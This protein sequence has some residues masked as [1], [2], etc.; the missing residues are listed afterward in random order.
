MPDTNVNLM[1]LGNRALLDSTP[2]SNITQTQAN[3]IRNWTAQGSDQ[4]EAV[5]LRGNYYETSDVNGPH[6][7]TT[8]LATSSAP[9]SQ[10][11]YTSPSTG[12]VVSGIRIQTFL[13][14]NYSIT[15]HDGAGNATVVK[16]TGVLIQ[17]SN[18]DLFFRPSTSTLN[19]W[20]NIDRISEVTIDSVSV[21]TSHVATMGFKASIFD[22][23][24]VCFTR[25]T[26][27]DTPD[28][29]RPVEDLRIGDLVLTLDRGA[30]PIRWIGSRKLDIELACIPRLRPVR[31]RA[32][33]LGAGVPKADL[34]VSP[35]HRVLLRSRIAARMFGAAEVLV[36]AKSLLGLDGIEVVDDLPE[37]EYF[38]FTFDQH[39]IV[40]AN[41]AE[42][43]SLFPGPEALKAVS[44]AARRELAEIFVDLANQS[45]EPAREIVKGARLRKLADRH[46]SNA[47][48]LV[49]Q[50]AMA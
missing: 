29:P 30:Q 31:I 14:A 1:W 34:L 49:D 33:A 35:Q 32:G 44:P 11:T 4:L 38:H 7:R 41:G 39:E 8:Y 45:P 23:T 9:A 47:R 37:V 16:Q 25:A 19:A 22:L 18:G 6:F 36:A 43:E 17:M 3:A 50:P 10:F 12:Q 5:S 24:V 40:F 13:Q 21:L 46:A 15:V 48:A 27:I 26:L 28:G 2:N 42:A 20:D